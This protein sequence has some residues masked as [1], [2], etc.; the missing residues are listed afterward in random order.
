MKNSGTSS[1]INNRFLRNT[2]L[3][4]KTFFQVFLLNLL[5]K[6]YYDKQIGW[7]CYIPLRAGL[8][9]VAVK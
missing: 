1:H 2:D 5:T 3:P 4:T 6:M 8:K 7:G 9:R